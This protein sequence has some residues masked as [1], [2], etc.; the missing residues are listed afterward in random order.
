MRAPA[1]ALAFALAG[2]A[3]A[4]AAADEG[5]WRL[6]LDRQLHQRP[7]QLMGIDDSRITYVDGAGIMRSE[8]AESFIAII[9]PLE[10]EEQIRRER[11]D[12][13]SDEL[14]GVL[15]LVDGQRIIGNVVPRQGEASP[16]ETITWSHSQLGEMEFR[17]D[18]IRRLALDS[19]DA[20]ARPGTGDVVILR[21]GDRLDGFVEGIGAAV[22]IEIGGQS[23]TLPLERISSILLANP[24]EPLSGRIAWLRDGSI[25]ACEALAPAQPGEIALVTRASQP[26]EGESMPAIRLPIS[27]ILAL[28]FDAEALAPLAGAEVVRQQ[29]TAGRR[30]S[31]PLRI[32]DRGGWALLGAADVEFPGPMFVEWQLPAGA[33]V[34]AAEA[35]LPH[36]N[37][38]WGDCELAVFLVPA[39]GDRNGGAAVEVEVFRARMNAEN[40][41]EL[42]HV[43]LGQATSGQEGPL[44]LRIQ[45]EPGEYGAV[46]DQIVLRRPLVLRE[47]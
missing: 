27:E 16:G 36:A 11:R 39:T 37:W 28:T 14:A 9:A 15:E 17:L 10:T 38:T 32:G 2:L 42:I 26:Q 13:S 47:R 3:C 35:E 41:H 29:A 46:Q 7:V 5:V 12:Q 21:N 24:P 8:A 6:L 45:L 1:P 23:R 43:P 33:A 40:P 19:R 44:R 25:I 20:A 31:P 30:W 34:F 22:Q 4:P 18:A